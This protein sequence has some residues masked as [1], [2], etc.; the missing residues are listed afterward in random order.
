MANPAQIVLGNE[1]VISAVVSGGTPWF[2]YAWTA[3]PTGCTSVNTSTLNCT[4]NEAG[5]FTITLVVTDSLNKTGSNT[6]QLVVA[7]TSGSG[8]G[9]GS[10]SSAAL[11]LFAGAMG[12][13]A[14][15][16]TATVLALIWRRRRRKAPPVMLSPAPYVPP[17]D[18][19]R[20]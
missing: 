2:K 13:V 8:A 19:E 4:P 12:T 10:S 18:Y 1:T 3:L 9:G 5:T 15:L 17:P 14:A 11:F 7:A 6:T 20:P 16:A